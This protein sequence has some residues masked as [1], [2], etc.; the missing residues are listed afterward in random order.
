MFLIYIDWQAVDWWSLVMYPPPHMTCMYPPPHIFT[1]RQWI[2]GHWGNL[3][4]V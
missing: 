3:P 4:Y 2:D 1:G